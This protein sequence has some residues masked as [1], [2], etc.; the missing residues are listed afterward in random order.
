METKDVLIRTIALGIFMSLMQTAAAGCIE[1]CKND[2]TNYYTEMCKNEVANI[3]LNDT[4]FN[5]SVINETSCRDDYFNDTYINETFCN[6]TF[7]NETLCDGTNE[8]YCNDT[9]LYDTFCNDTW[10]D[11][12]V[13]AFC[14]ITYEEW[15][16]IYSEAYCEV[17]WGEYFND[18][19]SN[20]CTTMCSINDTYKYP[21]IISPQLNPPPSDPGQEG[22]NVSKDNTYIVHFSSDDHSNY[23][24]YSIT[25]LQPTGDDPGATASIRVSGGQGLHSSLEAKVSA[26]ARAKI[27]AKV[28]AL[29]TP[30]PGATPAAVAKR[31]LKN[32]LVN[33]YSCNTYIIIWMNSI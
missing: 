33:L 9:W 17:V 14:N 19:I 11:M 29:S 24:I 26:N 1:E 4:E 10:I 7:L 23:Q 15:I 21:K 32:K 3:F 28:A 6:V 30:P 27:G 2:A 31:L 8:T 25:V 20:N 5:A 12:M 13:D 22:S 18:S 16:E